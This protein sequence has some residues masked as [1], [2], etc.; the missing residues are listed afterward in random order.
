MPAPGGWQG[1]MV[2]ASDGTW[3]LVVSCDET[4]MSQWV[5]IIPSTG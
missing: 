4:Y 3:N 5:K 2:V 1:E